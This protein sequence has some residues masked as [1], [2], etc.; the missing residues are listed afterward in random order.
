MAETEEIITII[1]REWLFKMISTYLVI[2][3]EVVSR[4]ALIGKQY[5]VHFIKLKKHVELIHC[6]YEKT[7]EVS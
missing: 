4:L 6:G 2:L 3:A 5:G 7:E 1:A